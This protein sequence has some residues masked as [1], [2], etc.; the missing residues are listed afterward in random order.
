MV[1]NEKK[2]WRCCGIEFRQ[3]INEVD[4]CNITDFIHEPNV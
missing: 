3:P 2:A 4:K 1:F